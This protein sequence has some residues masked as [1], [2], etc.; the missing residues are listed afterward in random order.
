MKKHNG[1][2]LQG[3]GL[4]VRCLGFIFVLTLPLCYSCKEGTETILMRAES[5][6]WQYPDSALTIISDIDFPEKLPDKLRADYGL[7]EAIAHFKLDMALDNDSLI[8]F[9]QDYYKRNSINDK[10]L[11]SYKF[12]ACHYLWH[13]DI[14]TAADLLDEGLQ[15]AKSLND[16]IAIVDFYSIKTEIQPASDAIESYR[17]KK[18]YN[19]RLEANSD[20]MIGLLCA[21]FGNRDSAKY[22]FERS[23]EIAIANKEEKATHYMRNYGDYLY[24]TKDIKGALREMKRALL[25]DPDY[26]SSN[27]YSSIAIIYINQNEIDSAQHY[28]NKAKDEYEKKTDKDSPDYITTKNTLLST[29]IVI[30]YARG[31]HI[32]SFSI[33]RYND[34]LR[35]AIIENNSRQEAQLA[36]KH[37]L[38]K[39]NLRLKIRHRDTQLLLTILIAVIG[40]ITCLFYIYVRN[41]RLKLQEIEEK[42]ETLKRLLNNVMA[43]G[44]NDDH[45]P[46]FFKKVLL[47]QL[48]LIRLIATT[49]TAQNQALL[50]QISLITNDELP[51]DSLLVWDD[52]YPLI[53]SIF[54]NFHSKVQ[55]KYKDIL[56]DKEIQL[57]CLLCADFSTKEISVVTQQSVRTI[58]QRKTTIRQR[59]QMD[60]K[61]DIVDFLKNQAA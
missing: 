42:N 4:K 22:Y 40:I 45:A 37:Q 25:Y 19:P 60:E 3:T 32:E 52:L 53:D 26:S 61:S 38:E 10:L 15:L 31:G 12:A 17:E 34:S 20:Y 14:K 54:N 9:S 51:T 46:D 29:Q 58:Y 44:T 13:K 11:L 18:R 33:G 35:Y 41:R 21:N 27:L 2:C 23:I 6:V 8:L 55:S 47:Q 7:I 59:L 50:Q 1:M 56:S 49:P 43:G 28:L 48:G 39:Q 16:S 36:I 5:V 57:C 30:D 24:A